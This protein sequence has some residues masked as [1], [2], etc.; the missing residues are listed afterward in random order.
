MENKDNVKMKK[1]RKW[2]IRKNVEGLLRE[3]E[4]GARKEKEVLSFVYEKI[5]GY[6]KTFKREKE[7]KGRLGKL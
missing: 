5:C 4:C 3:T 1:K 6:K 2:N 7:G